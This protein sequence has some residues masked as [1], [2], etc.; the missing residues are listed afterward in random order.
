MVALWS[1]NEHMDTEQQDK[2]HTNVRIPRELLERM[3]YLSRAHARSLNRE[4]E[5]A[6]REYVARHA[7]DEKQSAKQAS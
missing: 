6:V 5:V 3:R 2:A 1:Y 4:I 7:D